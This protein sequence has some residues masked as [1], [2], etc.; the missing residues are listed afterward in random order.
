MN[1]IANSIISK[2]RVRQLHTPHLG[3]K[4]PDSP[5]GFR[6]LLDRLRPSYKKVEARL[7]RKGREVSAMII[8]DGEIVHILEGS[9]MSPGEFE[10]EAANL[11]DF[12]KNPPILWAGCRGDL[13][14]E[15]GV[16]VGTP[17]Y[18]KWFDEMANQL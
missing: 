6:E 8:A 18:N 1:A 14:R 7:R 11:V 5:E 9:Q 17:C 10:T 13:A 12:Y 4:F 16:Q 15:L 2:V 3:Y